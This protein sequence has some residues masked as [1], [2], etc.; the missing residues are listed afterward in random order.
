ME[1]N[2]KALS[3]EVVAVKQRWGAEIKLQ[4]APKDAPGAPLPLCVARTIERPEAAYAFDVDDLT[5][6]LWIEGLDLKAAAAQP[7]AVDVSDEVGSSAA[8]AMPDDGLPVR[9]EISGPV[10]PALYPRMATHVRNRWATELRA[11]GTSHSWFLEKVLAWAEGAYIELLTL[12]QSLVEEYEGVNDEGM[13]IRRYTIAEPPPPKEEEEEDSDD[14]DSSDYESDG[15]DDVEGIDTKL[16]KMGLSEEAERAMRIKLKA[17]E[18]AQRAYREQ[19]RKEAEEDRERNGDAP[20]GG[21]SKKEQKKQKADK[22]E[23]KQG[24]RLRKAG[25]KHNKFDAEAAGAKKNKKNGLM[26]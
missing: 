21:L 9:V 17:E 13:T 5:V 6:K 7:P 12:D 22:T 24:T 10:P 1:D 23:K 8:A 2:K 25:A 20:G 19:R 18:E 26:H 16:A 15:D 11:R 14:E 4:K 3:A